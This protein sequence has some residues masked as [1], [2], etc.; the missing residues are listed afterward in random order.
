MANILSGLSFGKDVVD[1]T[2][3]LCRAI[4]IARG[5]DIDLRV[6]NVQLKVLEMRYSRCGE[7]LRARPNSEIDYLLQESCQTF[8]QVL[9]KAR[10]SVYGLNEEEISSST[11]IGQTM[12][13]ILNYRQRCRE[14]TIE[15]GPSGSRPR[16]TPS[17]SDRFCWVISTRERELPPFLFDGQE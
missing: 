13:S 3:H 9:A 15:A 16:R 11:V 2:L 10:T 5:S 8:D 12:E 6:F 7:M 17:F 1:A 14:A 4:R